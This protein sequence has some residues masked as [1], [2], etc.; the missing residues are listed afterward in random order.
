MREREFS[1]QL[2]CSNTGHTDC[3]R[4]LLVVPEIGF[5]SAAND[6]R[7]ILWSLDGTQ[8]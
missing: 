3:V 1:K 2:D 8:V 6:N 5:L 4:A 7:I